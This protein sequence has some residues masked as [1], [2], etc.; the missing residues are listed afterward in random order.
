MPKRFLP[1]LAL[2]FALA[3]QPGRA[4]EPIAIDWTLAPGAAS[5]QARLRIAVRAEQSTSTADIPAAELQGLG[6]P[7]ADGPVRFSL[8]REAGRLDCEGTVRERRG[9]GDCRFTGDE[10]FAGALERRGIG[11][12]D[13][14][15]QLELALRGVGL[16][17]VDELERQ[18]Y[19]PPTASNLVAVGIFRIDPAW[20]KALDAVGYRAGSIDKLVALRIFHVEPEWIREMEALGPNFRDLRPDTLVAMRIHRVTPEFARRMQAGYPDLT[21]ARLIALRLFDGRPLPGRA[22]R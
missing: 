17:L 6:D 21:P 11:R 15:E 22:A 4:A 12:P 1:A 3:A 20:L 9:A 8:V 14:R 5:G 18:G 13:T 19:R 7:P 2:T 10:A 16:A